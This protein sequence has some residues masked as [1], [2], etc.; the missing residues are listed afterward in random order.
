[1]LSVTRERVRWSRTHAVSAETFDFTADLWRSTS[2]AK[3]P[4]TRVR[5]KR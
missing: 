4:A 5:R 1:M 2:G 3:R